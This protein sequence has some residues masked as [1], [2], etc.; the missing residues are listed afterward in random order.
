MARRLPTTNEPQKTDAP[1]PVVT[2][3]GAAVKVIAE[4]AK[5]IPELGKAVAS[6]APAREPAPEVKVERF[7]VTNP[8]R[9][10][11]AG[12]PI[13]Y[14]GVRTL[15]TQGKIV[16]SNTYDLEYLKRQGVT[17]EPVDGG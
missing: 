12:F 17:L 6:A 4:A 9:P 1:A 14:G 15:L 11:M 10:G 2:E 5:T 13:L 7:R 16:D 8:P 3:E